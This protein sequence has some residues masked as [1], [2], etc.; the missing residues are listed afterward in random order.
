MDHVRICAIVIGKFH[1]SLGGN[2]SRYR[3]RSL[4]RVSRPVEETTRTILNIFTISE[5]SG[6]SNASFTSDRGSIVERRSHLC[7]LDDRE[8]EKR[9]GYHTARTSAPTLPFRGPCVE[10]NNVNRCNCEYRSCLRTDE[11][12]RCVNDV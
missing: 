9:G 4:S 12:P 8:V 5:L 11:M 3:R 1:C 2:Y 10:K 6:C 7:H